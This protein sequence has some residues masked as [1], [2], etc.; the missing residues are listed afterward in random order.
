MDTNSI[1]ELEKI[2]NQEIEAY[3]K[4]E[5]Y[6]SGKKQHLING[7]IEKIRIVD[8]ELEKYN[9]IVEKLE[10][11]RKLVYPDN[12]TLKEIIERIENKEQAN[13]ISNLRDKI[14]NLL[15]NIQKQNTINIELLKHSLK[16]VE[17]SIVIIANALV[18]EGSAYNKKG[19]TK[20][21][22][23]LFDLSSVEHEA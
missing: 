4:L 12:S 2:L 15:S 5:E 17:N 13:K 1:Y 3:S 23:R 19:A 10:E 14:K 18:P 7:D 21:S 22:K 11:K 8:L 16:I 9:Y 6:I 20:T